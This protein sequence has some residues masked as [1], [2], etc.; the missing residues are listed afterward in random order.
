MEH[1]QEHVHILLQDCSLVLITITIVEAIWW[2]QGGLEM[3]LDS[4][5]ATD[6][7]FKNP[8]LT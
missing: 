1:P 4:S 5:S 8:I 6:I 2:R 7:A 3:M